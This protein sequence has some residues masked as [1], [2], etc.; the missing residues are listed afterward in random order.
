M[1]LIYPPPLPVY[2]LRPC[3]ALSQPWGEGQEGPARDGNRAAKQMA[4]YLCEACHSSRLMQEGW[5]KKKSDRQSGAGGREEG[6]EENNS[7]TCRGA[8]FVVR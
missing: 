6:G 3:V 1:C 5:L 8:D 4:S 7:A 2:P